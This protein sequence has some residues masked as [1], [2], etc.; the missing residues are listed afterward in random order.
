[1]EAVGGTQ[2][3]DRDPIGAAV[4]QFSFRTC[5][6]VDLIFPVKCAR[7]DLRADFVEGE[8][9]E[10]RPGVCAFDPE[11]HIIDQGIAGSWSLMIYSYVVNF[12][13]SN[14]INFAFI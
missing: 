2:C 6:F 5:V 8:G 13:H 3:G 11:T 4:K 12:K 7:L 9:S 1:M 14:K 10:D